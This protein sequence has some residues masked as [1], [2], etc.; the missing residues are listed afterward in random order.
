MV[1]DGAREGLLKAREGLLRA[2]EGL[3]TAPRH[4]AVSR[5]LGRVLVL[6]LAAAVAKLVL[7]ESNI[8]STFVLS[9]F[10]ISIPRDRGTPVASPFMSLTIGCVP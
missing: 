7:E 5:V 8:F 3:L 4:E 10:L 9:V 1:A 2:R 6:N